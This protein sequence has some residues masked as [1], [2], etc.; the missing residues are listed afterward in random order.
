MFKLHKQI[1]LYPE[2]SEFQ[3]F[4]APKN[5][6]QFCR[7]CEAIYY[8]KSWHHPETFDINEIQMRHGQ[9]MP[10]TLCPACKM[11]ADHQ[12]EGILTITNIPKKSVGELYHM[13]QAYGHRA[14]AEDCQHRIINFYHPNLELWTVTTTENQLAN[15][16]GQK[17][18]DVFDKV[19]V[20]ISY[21]AQPDDLMRVNVHFETMPTPEPLAPK[22]ILYKNYALVQNKGRKNY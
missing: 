20:K 15:K 7:E 19:T 14:Y 8:N 10:T 12:Y 6:Y 11:I 5:S 1:M 13:I 16:L 3:E 18:K 9:T 2:R 17:I 22:K 21:S 4:G